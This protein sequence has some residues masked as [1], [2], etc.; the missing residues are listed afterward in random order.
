MA[1]EAERLRQLFVPGQRK[2][3]DNSSI[4]RKG[5]PTSEN[6]GSKSLPSPSGKYSRFT[7]ELKDDEDFFE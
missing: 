3:N 6:E 4:R 7:K 2:K 1:S 5:I